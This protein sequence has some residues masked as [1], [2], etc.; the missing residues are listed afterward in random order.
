MMRTAVFR[1]CGQACDRPE[2]RCRPVV[3]GDQ[4]AHLAAA[5]GEVERSRAIG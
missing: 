5:G 3:G 4:G 1:L 2:R